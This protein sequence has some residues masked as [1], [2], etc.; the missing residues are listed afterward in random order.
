M[1]SKAKSKAQDALLDAVATMAS[2]V[3][4]V[5][6]LLT[7][8]T[9]YETLTA[10]A[11]EPAPTADNDAAEPDEVIGT[12]N[13]KGPKVGKEAKAKTGIAAIDEDEVGENDLSAIV[14]RQLAQV[15]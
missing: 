11:A 10:P 5:S 14:S 15:D 12:A 1:D 2:D 4:E 9:A 6:E 7:L 3:E 13:V 8:I